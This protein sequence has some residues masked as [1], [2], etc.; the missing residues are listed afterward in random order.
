MRL[1]LCLLAVFVGW[2]L[3]VATPALAAGDDAAVHDAIAQIMS[4]DYP[5][6]L[7]PAKKKLQDQLAVCLKKSCSGSVK[8]EAHVA[9]GMVASQLGQ[10]DES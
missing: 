4:E 6:N 1:R 10:A 8:A 2:T 9:L 3:L 5:A 7:G